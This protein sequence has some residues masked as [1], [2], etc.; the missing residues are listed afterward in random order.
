MTT[1]TTATKVKTTTISLRAG[2]ETMRL[3]AQERK[4]GTATTF[5]TRTDDGSKQATRG[6]TA[7]HETFESAS[8]TLTRLASEAAALGWVRRMAGRGF[9]AAP[10]AFSTLPTPKAAENTSR[11]PVRLASAKK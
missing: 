2:N 4:N 3:F 5:V 7:V 8:K 1:A 10:D 6:M 11:K 9:A